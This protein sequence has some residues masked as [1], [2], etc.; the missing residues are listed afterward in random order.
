MA[1]QPAEGSPSIRCAATKSD[2]ASSTTPHPHA[3]GAG[4]IAASV[5][6]ARSW[7]A[8]Y[9]RACRL[10][11]LRSHAA[12]RVPDGMRAGGCPLSHVRIT[13]PSDAGSAYSAGLCTGDGWTAVR[14]PCSDCPRG[15]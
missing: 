6:R 8:S 11:R 5:A 10:G 15:W 3:Q 12:H 4:S 9:P 2:P 14:A 7:T 1:A 13:R